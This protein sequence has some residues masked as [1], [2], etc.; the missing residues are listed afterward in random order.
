VQGAGGARLGPLAPDGAGGET[1]RPT[2]PALGQILDLVAEAG[3]E[4]EALRLSGEELHHRLQRRPLS[5]LPDGVGVVDDQHGQ[6]AQGECGGAYPL[7]D[8]SRGGYQDVGRAGIAPAAAEGAH[9]GVH[10][11]GERGHGH[12]G[13]LGGLGGRH[14]DH[15]AH[16][17]A[18]LLSLVCGEPLA[19]AQRVG[20]RLPGPGA[21]AGHH[22]AAPSHHRDGA[23]LQGGG[24]DEVGFLQDGEERGGEVEI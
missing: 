23:R 18:L 16:P 20:E 17:R 24:G 13:A 4:D 11:L 22:V 1:E 5:H 6:G 10:R 8:R 21:G 15:G 14:Q 3:R 2:D 9:G 19:D 7:R 12:G